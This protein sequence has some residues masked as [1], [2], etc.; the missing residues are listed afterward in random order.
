M[1][2]GSVVFISVDDRLRSGAE[3]VAASLRRGDPRSAADRRPC[4]GPFIDPPLGRGALDLS[5]GAGASGPETA[6]VHNS[7]AD[8]S[9]AMLRRSGVRP[10][11]VGGIALSAAKRALAGGDVCS[12]KP[13]RAEKHASFSKSADRPRLAAR[14][15]PRLC[16]VALMRAPAAGDAVR[17]CRRLRRY[18]APAPSK[19]HVCCTAAE[20]NRRRFPRTRRSRRKSVIECG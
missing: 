18:G 9:R 20:L 16:A 5:R 7:G 10:G 15:A 12:P 13:G 8:A 6:C 19:A 14:A 1:K 3:I 2:T 11:A 17:A 4:Y